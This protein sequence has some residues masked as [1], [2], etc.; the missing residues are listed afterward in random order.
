M[1]KTFFALNLCI[2]L[3]LLGGM[4]FV[5]VRLED[6]KADLEELDKLLQDK[7]AAVSDEHSA[8][9]TQVGELEARLKELA[10]QVEKLSSYETTNA[11]LEYRVKKVMEDEWK[12]WQ[13]SIEDERRKWRDVEL[14]PEQEKRATELLHEG[15]DNFA[16]IR[17]QVQDG[18]ISRDEARKL[19]REQWRKGFAKFRETLDEEQLKRFGLE[20]EGADGGKK[21]E[22][23]G[24]DAV[25]EDK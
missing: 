23:D 17:K 4:V 14:K 2:C 7:I 5:A 11:D 15:I 18:E 1:M 20:A 24:E 21:P 10:G 25:E 19:M 3:A 9:L 6:T 16:E 13:R 8:T 22:G 12:K